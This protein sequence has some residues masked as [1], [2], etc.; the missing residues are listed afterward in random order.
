MAMAR[1]MA[2]ELGWG[3]AEIAEQI[4]IWHRVA[5]VEGLVPG[6]PVEDAEHV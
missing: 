1:A 4:E 2:P 6:A 5:A 3:E